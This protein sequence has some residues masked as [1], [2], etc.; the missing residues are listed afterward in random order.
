M[1]APQRVVRTEVVSAGPVEALAALLDIAVSQDVLPPLWHQTHLLE[2]PAQRD[3]GPD[4]HP[5]HGIPAPPGPGHKR[6]FAGGRV[7]THRPIVVGREATR[8]TWLARTE[9]KTGRSGTLTFVT[10]RSEYTQDGEVAVAEEADIV[11]RA[12][13]STVPATPGS[14]DDPPY[15]A[16]ASPFLTLRADERLLFRFSALT[17]NAHRIH[18]D[19]TWARLEG[20][21]GMVV[22]GPLQALMLA[23]LARRHGVDLVGRRFTY[24][25]VAPMTGTQ[26]FTVAAARD[27]L[28]TGAEARDVHGTVTAVS[29]LG[30]LPDGRGHSSASS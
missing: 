18:Y 30:P 21:G 27:G 29:V 23:E 24:R 13:G 15:Q 2:R 9:E 5:V 14:L 26:T 6:M 25:L 19:L 3:L 28:D 16:P 4:G 12:S 11:Y 8:T 20:Y 1:P 10:V 7:D 17:Y 22:H